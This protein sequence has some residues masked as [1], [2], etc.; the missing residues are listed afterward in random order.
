MLLHANIG[1][2][3]WLTVMFYATVLSVPC[4]VEGHWQRGLQ[5]TFLWKQPCWAHVSIGQLPKG[6]PPLSLF[7]S[8]RCV[9][10][11]WGRHFYSLSLSLPPPP[12]SKPLA[13]PP[14][15]WSSFCTGPLLPLLV[16]FGLFSMQGSGEPLEVYHIALI[17]CLNV[18]VAPASLPVLNTVLRWACQAH[19]C[20][21]TR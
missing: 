16:P 18:P 20:C 3:F 21:W 2:S 19:S 5:W 10:R 7:P 14:D 17:L 1:H 6:L 9:S 4:P 8:P 15:S 11:E 13:S 12:K